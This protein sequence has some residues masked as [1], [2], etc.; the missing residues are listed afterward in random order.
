MFLEFLTILTCDLYKDPKAK[1]ALGSTKDRGI[2]FPQEPLSLP[3]QQS[4]H[5]SFQ[6]AGHLQDSLPL[7]KKN[8]GGSHPLHCQ[9]QTLPKR[10]SIL[11]ILGGLMPP[12][13]LPPKRERA[14]I[15]GNSGNILSNRK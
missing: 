12:A 9:E 15:T 5:I 14:I 7:Q 1:A 4:D 13:C 2:H 6:M 11:G 8:L 10:G 3:T